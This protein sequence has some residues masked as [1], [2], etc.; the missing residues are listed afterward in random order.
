SK[1]MPA[2]RAES[3]MQPRACEV[4]DG[5]G[6]EVD[7]CE[8][9]FVEIERKSLWP[10]GEFERLP[11]GKRVEEDSRCWASRF[12]SDAANPH[13]PGQRGRR[14][15]LCAGTDW[16]D[17]LCHQLSMAEGNIVLDIQITE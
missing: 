1:N 12:L 7:A 6:E 9:L 14:S 5:S 2:N 15:F 17:I 8:R 16:P 4:R 3:V 10:L 11:D 13:R